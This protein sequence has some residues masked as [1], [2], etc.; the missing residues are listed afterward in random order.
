MQY[1]HNEVFKTT[2]QGSFPHK[3]LFLRSSEELLKDLVDKRARYVMVSAIYLFWSYN[4]FSELVLTYFPFR[5]SY[6][7]FTIK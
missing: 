5:I 1:I 7:W 4:L 3:Y 6:K 2:A